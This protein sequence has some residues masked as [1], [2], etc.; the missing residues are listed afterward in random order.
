MKPVSAERFGLTV[1]LEK[2]PRSVQGD[3]ST[4]GGAWQRYSGFVLNPGLL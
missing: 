2:M 4:T 1:P 3:P